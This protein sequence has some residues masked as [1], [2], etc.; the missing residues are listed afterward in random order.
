MKKY[1]LEFCFK[2]SRTYVQ[3]PD[4]FD[5]VMKTIKNDFDLFKITDIKYAAHDMLLANAN[6]IVTDQFNKDDFDMINSIITF[7]QDDIKYYAVVFQNDNKIECS[8][9]YSEEI[10]R[11]ESII[12]DKI[13]I[14]ENVLEDSITE[15]A[16]SMNKYFLQETET[17]DGKWIVTKFEYPKLINLD[18]IKN[19]TLKLEL[20]NNFNNKLTKSTI[21]VNDEVVGYL[22]FSLI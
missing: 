4:I 3:G 15:I 7:K 20:T 19:K 14:F 10:V 2:G 18:K 17:K 9:E 21:F 12:K 11:T 5:T 16:V 1:S 13:I 22:Y 6:L 8:N